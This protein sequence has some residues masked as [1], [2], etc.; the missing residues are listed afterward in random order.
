MKLL[1]HCLVSCHTAPFALGAGEMLRFRRLF[2][3]VF[4]D[5]ASHVLGYQDFKRKSRFV[6]QVVLKTPS[7]M[8][9]LRYIFFLGGWGID[10]FHQIH[11]SKNKWKF[12]LKDGVMSF[13][14]KDH[15]FSK[16]IGDAEW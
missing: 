6:N 15:I 5:S 12:S 7:L 1:H 2:P 3:C 8:D 9:G 16:A 14:G 10:F 13:E 11:R 4:S